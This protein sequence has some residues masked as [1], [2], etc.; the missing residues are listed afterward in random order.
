MFEI[1]E[2][3]FKKFAETGKTPDCHDAYFVAERKKAGK[4]MP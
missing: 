1:C 3:Q 4:P 2:A